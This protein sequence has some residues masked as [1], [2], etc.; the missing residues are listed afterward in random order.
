VRVLVVEDETAL[1]DA[2]ARGLRR[3]GMSVDVAYDGHEGYGKA[4]SHGYNVL[5]LDRDLP[6]VSGGTTATEQLPPTD[7][8]C[9]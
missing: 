4:T 5:A 9:R 2:V 1:A 7:G 6:G 8:R 3:R